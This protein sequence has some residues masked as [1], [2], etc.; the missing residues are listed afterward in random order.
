MTFQNAVKLWEFPIF[1]RPTPAP[2]TRQR[3]PYKED[4]IP[5]IFPKFWKDVETLG[6]LGTQIRDLSH[7]EYYVFERQ[8]SLT[9]HYINCT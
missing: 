9:K 2:A 5:A 4:E 8:F 6:I 7:N 3:L 1:R